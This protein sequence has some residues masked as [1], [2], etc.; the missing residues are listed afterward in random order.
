MYGNVSGCITRGADSHAGIQSSIRGHHLLNHQLTVD[1]MDM[2]RGWN[3][4]E[5]DATGNGEYSYFVL[6]NC[7]N[8]NCH[9]AHIVLVYE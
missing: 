1:N 9:E 4:K 8:I 6:L 2:T 5:R 3:L 7:T